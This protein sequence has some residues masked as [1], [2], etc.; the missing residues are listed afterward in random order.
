MGEAFQGL[1]VRGK[2]LLVVGVSLALLSLLLGEKDLLRVGLLAG[3]LPLLAAAVLARTR[4]RLIATRVL[5]PVRVE[6][7]QTARVTLRLRNAS[8]VPT[9]TMMLEDSLP[10]SLG[11]RPRLVLE[12]LL[13]GGSSAVTYTVRADRRGKY[14]I[15]PLIVRITDPFGLIELTRTYPSTDHLTATPR[16][17]RLPAVRLPG[18]YTGHGDNRSRAVAVHGDDD[19]ATREY[20]HGDD[21]RRVH[22]KST[23]RVGELMVRREEQPWDS[24]A[25]ITMDL[26]SAGYR[27][28]GPASSFE[29]SVEATAAVAAHL[30]MSGYKL[31]MVSEAVDLTPETAVQANILDHLAEV[32]TRRT[33]SMD[34]LVERIK[35]GD[36]GGLVIGVFGMM[37]VQ[38]AARLATLR[39]SGTTCIA[40]LVDSSTWMSLPESAR[41]EADEAFNDTVLTLMRGGWRVLQIRHNEPLEHQW[42]SLA[43]GSQ[44]FSRR[45]ALAET[46]SGG[47]RR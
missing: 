44:G 41:H 36:R 12:R 16:I 30:Q 11:E 27:G 45:A 38:E 22:W 24:R 33:A 10:Y 20:R 40:V 4:Y 3:L 31:R 13:G 15:G 35:R 2:G 37:S 42:H 5:D 26:R 8:R 18:E 39:T 23:A 9:G 28:D 7:G 34:A 6:V 21:L 14:D 29:W 46:I 25:V 19:A 1:T 43:H 17:V 32:G 47:P